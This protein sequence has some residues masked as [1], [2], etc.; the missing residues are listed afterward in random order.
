M[1]M[2]NSHECI[3]Y[4]LRIFNGSFVTLVALAKAA[5]ALWLVTWLFPRLSHCVLKS[6]GCRNAEALL[7][8]LSLRTASSMWPLCHLSDVCCQ[9]IHHLTDLLTHSS[10]CHLWACPSASILHTPAA[11]HSDVPA[12]CHRSPAKL[13]LFLVTAIISF[14]RWFYSFFLNLP[15]NIS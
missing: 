4:N 1:Q 8:L 15:L 11:A 2:I 13:V 7:P 10:F 3:M 12:A 9:L 5:Q 6:F 14:V